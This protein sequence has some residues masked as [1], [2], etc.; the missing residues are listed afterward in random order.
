MNLAMPSYSVTLLLSCI[1][2]YCSGC[3]S[4]ASENISIEQHLVQ[5]EASDQISLDN[6]DSSCSYFY[7]LW[8]THAEINK[9]YTEAE[10]AFEKALICDPDSKY[11][12][13]RLPILLIRMGK[14]LG[15]A[16]WL[17]TAI[18]KYPDDLQDRLLLARLDI[19]N[20]EIDEAI[21]LYNELITMTP[22]DETLF[23]RL[24]FLYSEQQQ[25]SKAEQ[26]F[27][28]ALKLNKDSLF[29]H[30]YL[31]RL[32]TQTNNIKTAEKWYKKAIKIN[33]SVELVLELAEFY[34]RQKNYKK[35]EKQY[36]SILKK[37]PAETRA[38]LG[39]V[40]TLLLQ[41]KD[42]KA[43]TVLQK[44]RENNN[45][46][47]QIDIITAKLHLRAKQFDK[48][49]LVLAPI[50]D[51]K[52][53]PEATYMLAVILYQQK[54]LV[55]AMELLHTIEQGASHF[56]DSIFLQVRIF[57]EQ[58]QNNRAI[59]LLTQTLLNK[60]LVT[61]GLYSLLA[62]LYME[63]D[64]VSKGYELLDIALI[65]YPENPELYFEYGLL[66]EQ[67]GSQKRA[68]T[69]MEKVLE[70]NPDHTE[71]LNFL[72]YTWADNNINLEKAL[73]YIQKAI[74]IKSDSGYIRDSLAWVYFRM[75]KLEL[76]TQEI[77]EALTL[78]PT[79]PNIYEHLGDIHLAQEQKEEALAAYQKAVEL[80]TK[81][82][83]KSRLFQKIEWLQEQ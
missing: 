16:K 50:A 28:Q 32:A 1:F 65:R 47:V 26:S 35:V 38:G 24:G 45:D 75:G 23:L 41:D 31:A 69:F 3:S 25:Y 20:N 51:G 82:S 9:D 5:E 12:L 78:E 8:G 22:E 40:H 13:R 33:W 57:M 36:Q 61:P 44:L 72:G 59:E 19:R 73:E 14:P 18:Q 49:A 60:A 39:L 79:D 53:S 64:Q 68:I 52:N 30:L 62:S 70:I 56:E 10:E 11:V 2:L 4:T 29:A 54:K 83:D 27:K 66:L 48:A 74:E 63:Q 58:D 17:R 77:M 7:F 71:A 15:A 37:N 67:D 43:L 55:S 42:E 34:E 21:K 80:F 81:T 6:S 46:S 76:A